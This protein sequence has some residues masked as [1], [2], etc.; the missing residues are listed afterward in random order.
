MLQAEGTEVNSKEMLAKSTF[1]EMD[2]NGDGKVKTSQPK[3]KTKT[4]KKKRWTRMEM[5][6]WGPYTCNIISTPLLATCCHSVGGPKIQD[7]IWEVIIWQSRRHN[8]VLYIY[9]V[10][11][12]E[13]FFTSELNLFKAKITRLYHQVT[14]AEFTQAILGDDKFSRLLAVSVMQMFVWAL[15]RIQIQIRK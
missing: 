4:T 8:F 2:K 12:A 13:Q 9:P 7:S 1:T 6:R 3:T 11:S 15:Q 5:G 10:T 14:S